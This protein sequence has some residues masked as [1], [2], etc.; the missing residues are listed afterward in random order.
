MLGLGRPRVFLPSQEPAS[1][2]VNSR[3]SLLKPE[4]MGG[5]GAMGGSAMAPPHLAR[6]QPPCRQVWTQ[7]PAQPSPAVPSLDP[8]NGPPAPQTHA[9]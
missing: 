5:L 6:P 2:H 7:D 4:P 3:P 9:E 1:N 8:Q